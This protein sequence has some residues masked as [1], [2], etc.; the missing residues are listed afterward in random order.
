MITFKDH[1]SGHAADYRRF[2]PAYPPQLFAFL[3]EVTPNRE[4]AWD[5]GTGNG[6]AAVALA[7]HFQKVFAT[8]ASAEQLNNAEAN[9]RVEY[10]VAPAERS[11]LPDGSA[12]IV[13]VAQAF[14]WF[15]FERF[16]AEVRRVL[17]PGGMLAVWSVDTRLGN[18][19][20]D[21][22]LG[23]VIEEVAP[24]WPPERAH[25]DDRYRNIPFPFAEIPTPSFVMNQEWD[26]QQIIGY[27]NTWSATKQF[28][29]ASRV[30]PL[31]RY[32]PQLAAAWG[33]PLQRRT[34]HWDLTVRV[35]RVTAA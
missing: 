34:F 18:D 7:E 13:T 20:I 19:A 33:D 5:C 31:E 8:D 9:P 3:A 11:P 14:H 24:Y 10:V 28:V 2:R 35:G 1:F 23:A 12:S 16:F 21:E 26:L 27:I 4:L 17:Q 25:V 6:Q 29:E 32:G 22:I 15:D 30:S